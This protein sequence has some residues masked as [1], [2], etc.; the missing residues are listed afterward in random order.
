[1]RRLVVLLLAVSAV[2]MHGQKPAYPFRDPSLPVEQRVADLLGRMTPAE[3]ISQM[4]DNAPA[5]DRLGIPHYVWGNEGLHGVADAGF[6]TEFPQVI[7]MAATWDPKLAHRMAEVISTEARAKYS[8]AVAR[9]IRERFYGLT[10]WAPN[11]NIFRDP[12]WGRGQETYGEDPLLT[13]RMGVAYVTGLQGDDPRYLRAVAGPKH[14][15]AHSGPEAV[16]HE[17]NSEVSAYD[18]ADTYLP[19]FRAVVEQGKAA[20]VMCSYNRINGVPSCA[21]PWLLGDEL[22]GKWHFTGYVVSDCGAIDDIASGHKFTSDTEHSSAAAVKAG[23]DMECDWV[24]D[25]ERTE[26][27]YLNEGLKDGLIDLPAIDRALSRILA[28]RFRL[29]FFDPPGSNPYE[30]LRLT[31][32]LRA[33]DHAEALKAAREAIVL[34]RNSDS[35]LPLRPGVRLAVVG[36]TADL[37]QSLNGNYN[38]PPE[39]PITPLAGLL[40]QFNVQY[41]QGSMLV[42]GSA[43]PV[44]RSVLS[45]TEAGKEVEGL[46]GEYFANAEFAGSPAA[47]RTDATVNF[48][49]DNAVVLPGLER[50][51][52]SVRWSGRFTPPAPGDYKLGAKVRGCYVC[53]RL[54]HYR[55]FLDGQQLSDA[56]TKEQM[57]SVHFDDTK[58]HDLKLEFSY[59]W[60]ET[61]RMHSSGIDLIWLPP[62]QVLREDAVRAAKN[63]DVVV[64]F[65]GLS[66]ELEGEDLP[67][68][69]PGFHRGDRTSIQLPQIQQELLRSLLAT[70]K[71]VALVLT[72]GSAV[73]L[74]ADLTPHTIL[75]AWYSGEAGGT[76]I[77]ETLAGQN[78]PSGRLPVTFYQSEDQLPAFG[79]YSMKNRTYRYFSEKP[80]FRFGDGLSYTSFSYSGLQVTPA[81]DSGGV[82][83][84]VTLH[85]T[86]KISGT[87]VVEV[88]LDP[89]SSDK[90][91]R[92]R[93]V[94]FERVLLQPGEQRQVSLF[95]PQE[96]FE[97]L[98]E[99]GNAVPLSG[100]FRVS[101]GGSQPGGTSETL[102]SVISQ[103]LRPYGRNE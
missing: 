94:D 22:R 58:P 59:T 24:Q 4:Q 88:Y 66:P 93:L 6:A 74:A 68:D 32:T 87:E 62:A 25:G 34:L 49:W 26:Y 54:E 28:V 46:K 19:A 97:G 64:L 17:W 102:S 41:A 50:N 36:P 33:N 86:G 57:V 38:P 90:A 2:G 53:S 51:R 11:I 44:S 37:T 79:D 63:S 61:H 45:H 43:L 48:D 12:R 29:G 23:T 89:P 103:S 81:G 95:L 98:D 5:I 18:L 92:R 35:L 76:A 100:T 67:V 15:A 39:N 20:S 27:S 78:N 101:V 13:A 75:E 83:L 8:D 47:I 82:Q 99:K 60:V 96:S 80:W 9:G 42:E 16:R 85:N 77:A 65:A 14:F 56:T 40:K 71:P 1:M 55:F 3:K 70:G 84:R 21:N 10:F 73:A 91:P 52:Y 31:P 30:R 69:I 72:T 7:G